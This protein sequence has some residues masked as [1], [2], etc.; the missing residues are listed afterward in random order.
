MNTKKDIIV[1]ADDDPDDQILI[2]QMFSIHSKHVTVINVMNGKEALEAIE[3]LKQVEE[4]PCLIIL[5]INMPIMDGKQALLQI[6]KQEELLDVPVVL[7]STSG[8]A[9][10]QVFAK[11]HGDDY[12]T[13]PFSYEKLENVVRGFIRQCMLAR[14]SGMQLPEVF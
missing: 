8:N 1:F 5:D 4:T 2:K 3:E 11:T 12:V 9:R 6:K 13:K 7:F 14:Q 10:D